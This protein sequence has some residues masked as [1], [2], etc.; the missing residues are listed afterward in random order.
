MSLSWL[1][2][3][4]LANYNKGMCYV[5]PKLVLRLVNSNNANQRVRTMAPVEHASEVHFVNAN[6]DECLPLHLSATLV[7]I[8][9]HLPIRT[10]NATKLE[11]P[12]QNS[13]LGNEF[14]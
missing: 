5:I 3:F 8:H 1:A 7:L 9:E 6:C 10:T 11:V 13:T 2:F 12:R 14:N 4:E